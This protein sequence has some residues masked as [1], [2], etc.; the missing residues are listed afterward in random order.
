MIRDPI[1]SISFHISYSNMHANTI[2]T[3]FKSNMTFTI[4]QRST[5]HNIIYVSYMMYMVWI[6]HGYTY[7]SKSYFLCILH[8]IKSFLTFTITYAS[9]N[10]LQITSHTLYIIILEFIS[11]IR[12][13]NYLF[14]FPMYFILPIKFLVIHNMYLPSLIPSFP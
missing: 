14:E 7:I 11:I 4:I 5:S 8:K 9:K 10:L 13:I 3:K 12:I 2:G 1:G 6:I